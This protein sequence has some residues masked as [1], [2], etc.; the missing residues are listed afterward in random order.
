MKYIMKRKYCDFFW[1]SF[2]KLNVVL[3][4]FPLDFLTNLISAS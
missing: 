4:F 1:N 2:L 3:L